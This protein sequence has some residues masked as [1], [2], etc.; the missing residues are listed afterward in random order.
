MARVLIAEARLRPHLPSRQIAAIRRGRAATYAA[1]PVDVRSAAA[2]PLWPLRESLP[3]LWSDLKGRPA[4]VGVVVAALRSAGRPVR[5]ERKRTTI[6]FRDAAGRATRALGSTLADG[7]RI[8]IRLDPSLEAF[9]NRLQPVPTLVY[10]SFNAQNAAANRQLCEAARGGTIG[11]H[12]FI[13]CLAALEA[14]VGAETFR[15][16]FDRA[17]SVG[18]AERT[19]AGWAWHSQ[20]GPFFRRVGDRPGVF[21]RTGGYPYAIFGPLYDAQRLHVAANE[22]SVRPW[23]SAVLLDRLRF[24]G[25]EYGMTPDYI[26]SYDRYLSHHAGGSFEYGLHAALPWAARREL[27][28]LECGPELADKLGAATTAVRVVWLP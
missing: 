20:P 9:E 15:V 19:E 1:S 3:T 8:D 7:E 21:V 25:A 22:R 11:R 13:L 10:E 24:F 4:C 18:G 5:V 6:T 12:D 17:E 23:A 26:R 28:R 27:A 16:W 2:A 14:L